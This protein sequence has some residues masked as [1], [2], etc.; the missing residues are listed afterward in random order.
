[1]SA[2]DDLL[3]VQDIDTHLDQLRHRRETLPELAELAALGERLSA[4]R[5]ARDEVAGRLRTVRSAQKEA[6]DHASLL[7][8]KAREVHAAMYDGTVVAHKELEALQEEHTSLQA[9]QG[10]FED[11][12][13]E[14]MEQAEPVE[15]ELAAVESSVTEL[16]AQ[17]ADA[18]ARLLVA[19]AELDV[20]LEAAESERA[21]A[22]ALVPE[23]L[24]GAYE[25]LRQGLGG[26]AV[27]RLNGARCEGCHLEIPS[28]ELEELRRAPEDQPV[29]CPECLRI[30][31]R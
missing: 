3:S 30:L 19:R 11:R 18:D 21:A 20:Q 2:L 5:S 22:A 17:V 10:E 27:A 25:P 6:E 15:A 9:R 1:M 28:A 31:V 29:H 23:D 4:A 8:D 12:A 26:I 14:L 13:L 24:L 16:E 7:E